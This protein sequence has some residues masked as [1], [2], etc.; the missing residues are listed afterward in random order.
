MENEAHDFLI[1]SD[2]DIVMMEDVEIQQRYFLDGSFFGV[3]TQFID[4]GGVMIQFYG[5]VTSR[6]VFC[7]MGT[8]TDLH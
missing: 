7:M 8:P 4:D 2:G 1:D 6:L 5:P 3:E